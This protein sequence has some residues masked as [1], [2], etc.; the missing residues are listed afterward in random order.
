MHSIKKYKSITAVVVLPFFKLINIFFMHVGQTF[1]K[2]FFS[3]I[4]GFVK[5]S[6][7]KL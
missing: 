4:F 2:D 5:Y 6:T 1:F 7:K 3:Q